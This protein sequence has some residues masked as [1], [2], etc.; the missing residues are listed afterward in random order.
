VVGLSTVEDL[1]AEAAQYTF[2][3]PPP[4]PDVLPVLG[5]GDLRVS[6]TSQGLVEVVHVPSRRT[7]VRVDATDACS[8]ISALSSAVGAV[9]SGLTRIKPE[10][11]A[12]VPAP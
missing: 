8:L 1:A 9:T 3:S 5:F 7:L 12:E 6:A 2:P 4:P 10:P 11:A